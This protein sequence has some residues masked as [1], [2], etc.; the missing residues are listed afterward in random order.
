[1]AVEDDQLLAK[2]GVLEHQLPLAAGP[3]EGG[4]GDR[5]IVSGLFPA[6]KKV[7]DGLEAATNALSHEG[8]ESRDRSLSFMS[9]YGGWDSTTDR[10][11]RP[12]C[13]DGWGF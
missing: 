7:L 8:E 12:Q 6:A 2:Y 3:V 13:S 1:M 9:E 11:D 10:R 5:G 4:V